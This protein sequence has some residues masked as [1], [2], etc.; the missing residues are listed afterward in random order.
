MTKK[1][2]TYLILVLCQLIP[3]TLIMRAIAQGLTVLSFF[4][5]LF[6]IFA[7]FFSTS[8]VP[9]LKKWLLSTCIAF[10]VITIVGCLVDSP[11][12]HIPDFILLSLQLL[13]GKLT[14]F[15]AMIVVYKGMKHFAYNEKMSLKS[16]KNELICLLISLPSFLIIP[17]LTHRVYVTFGKW[18]SFCL[19]IITAITILLWGA[20]HWRKLLKAQNF[21]AIHKFKKVGLTTALVIPTTVVWFGIIIFVIMMSKMRFF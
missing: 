6:Y 16:V 19:L 5:Y 18:W 13:F 20:S 3:I 14:A 7:I 12:Y 17:F 1:E 4:A 8:Y 11:L 21:K 15:S 9:S 10:V 2:K